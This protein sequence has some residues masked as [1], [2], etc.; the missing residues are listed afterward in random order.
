MSSHPVAGI[1]LPDAV[2]GHPALD[3]CNTRAAWGAQQPKEYLT[4]PLALALWAW[5]TGLAPGGSPGGA[6]LT[7]TTAEEVE[8]AVRARPAEGSA[9]LRRALALREAMYRCA[10]GRGEA[11]HW[12]VVSRE[13]VAAR[14]ASTLVTGP[15]GARWVLA[16]GVGPA[17]LGLHAAAGCAEDLLTSP[18]ITCVAACPGAGCGWLFADRRRRRR[19]CS[20]ALCGN[21]AKA[22]RHAER[23]P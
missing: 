14:A 3:F 16:D 11:S 10:L 21:R 23:H 9:A 2:G 19:W 12:Q 15:T 5:D 13:A 7:P 17:L 20:M 1:P 8:A 18:L 22:R 4:S 6:G